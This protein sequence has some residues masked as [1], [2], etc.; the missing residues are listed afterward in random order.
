MR[1]GVTDAVFS[2]VETQDVHVIL[3]VE[4][5][6]TGQGGSEPLRYQFK[7]LTTLRTKG[8]KDPKSTALARSTARRLPGGPTAK[9]VRNSNRKSNLL[10][11]YL[12]T[13]AWG[14]WV[15]QV[16]LYTLVFVQGKARVRGLHSST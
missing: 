1:S 13:M 8:H 11:S 10:T 16:L 6:G 9:R 15:H 4:A 3:G 14:T 12:G 5:K 7:T 2:E